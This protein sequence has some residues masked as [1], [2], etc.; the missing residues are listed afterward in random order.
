MEGVGWFGELVGGGSRVGGD[1]LWGKGG[2]TGTDVCSD[3]TFFS[4]S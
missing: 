3:R 2:D 4:S 1:G